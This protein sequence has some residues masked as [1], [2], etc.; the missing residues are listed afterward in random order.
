MELVEEQD[1][2]DHFYV[3]VYPNDLNMRAELTRFD[4]GIEVVNSIDN[5]FTLP[6][7]IP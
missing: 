7:V 2:I 4:M 1:P 6:I 3:D 5:F